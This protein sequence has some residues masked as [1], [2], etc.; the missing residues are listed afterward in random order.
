[1]VRELWFVLVWHRAYFERHWLDVS[2]D[3][4]LEQTA[5]LVAGHPLS[6]YLKILAWDGVKRRQATAE[7][8]RSSSFEWYFFCRRT[9]K[10]D[11]A[12]ARHWAETYLN[13]PTAHEEGQP[14]FKAVTFHILE[15]RFDKARGIYREEFA[16]DPDPFF[17]LLGRAVERQV[18]GRQDPR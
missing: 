7:R 8:Y 14:Q 15:K 12:A 4:F 3:E 5:P 18:E 10:G 9:G 6:P 2:A 1:L 17:G 11:M 16:K 13:D